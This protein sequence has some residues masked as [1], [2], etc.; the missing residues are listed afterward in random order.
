[1]RGLVERG[2]PATLVGQMTDRGRQLVHPDGRLE[3][4]DRLDRDELYRILE[5]RRTV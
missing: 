4:V 5:E 2:I 1:V 3:E